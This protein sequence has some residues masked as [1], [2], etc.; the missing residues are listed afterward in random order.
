MSTSVEAKPPTPEQLNGHVSG[1]ADTPT[2]GES[3]GG[4]HSGARFLGIL[5]VMLGGLFLVA[6]A[7]GTDWAGRGWPLLVIV[8][9]L[10][11]FA[12]AV[13]GGKDCHWLAVPASIITTVGAILWCQNA[14]NLWQT[15]AY[16]WAL[17]FPTAIGFGQL[18]EGT[19]GERP[20][21]QQQGRHSMLVGA[22]V[23]ICFAAFFEGLLNLSG[24]A[25]V[26]GLRYLLP[27]LLILIGVGVLVQG[28]ARQHSPD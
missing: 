8:P 24:L 2:R 15:W 7:F 3:T 23:F 14:F 10:G 12:I 1:A 26:A 27:L 11:L 21:L 19:L 17:V 25:P 18:L 20:Q 5:L 6:P 9:G 16:A 22:L 28:R 13:F 4:L